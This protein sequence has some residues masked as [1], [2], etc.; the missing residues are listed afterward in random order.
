MF[1]LGWA[2]ESEFRCFYELAAIDA[3]DQFLK[4]IPGTKFIL[5][6]IADP[7]PLVLYTYSANL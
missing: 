6:C 3:I 7:Q 2:S 1:I 5:I 4:F